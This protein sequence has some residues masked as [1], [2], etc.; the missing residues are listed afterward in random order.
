MKLTQEQLEAIR[1]RAENA[2]PGPWQ[3]ATTT[4]GAYVLD[5]D[6]MI[7]AATIERTEDASFI[8]H[9]R[10]DIPA[11]LD[12]IAELEAELAILKQ[13]GVHTICPHCGAVDDYSVSGESYDYGGSYLITCGRC[14]ESIESGEEY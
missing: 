8:A 9:A 13:P 12:H 3:I 7:I 1:Q 11:L 5:T 6:D 10:T 4:D 14:S 2:T